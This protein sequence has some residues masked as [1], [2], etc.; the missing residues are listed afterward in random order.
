[1]GFNNQPYIP[2]LRRSS[3]ITD[4][5]FLLAVDKLRFLHSDKPSGVIT[6][7][8]WVFI[9]DLAKELNIHSNRVRS[10]MRRLKKRKLIYGCNCGCRGD[11]EL[12]WF[13]QIKIWESRFDKTY[14][15][16]LKGEI[17]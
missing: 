9:S 14:L 17:V 8:S 12:T 5:E 7:A 6:R 2:Y 4:L 13:G 15:R 1:M 11:V 3:T 16:Y 10:K